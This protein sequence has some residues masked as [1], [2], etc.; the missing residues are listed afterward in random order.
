M[1]TIAVDAMGGD[2]CPKAEVSGAILAIKSYDVR[3]ILVGREDVGARRAGTARRLGSVPHSSSITRVSRSRWRTAPRKLSARRRTPPFASPPGWFAK[4][5]PMV[6]FRPATPAP[7]WRPPK[8]CREWCPVSIGPRWRPSFPSLKGT[9]VVVVDVGANVD[10]EPKM[11]AQFAVMGD[12]Y[13][14]SHLQA[15]Q[16]RESACSRSAKKSTKATSSRKSATPLLKAIPSLN[17]IGNVEGRDLYTGHA[18][19]IVCDGFIGNVALKVSEGIVDVIKQMLKESLQATVTPADRLPAV[20]I[21]VH[22]IQEACRL[23]RIRRRA[24]AR[25]EGRLHHL[26]RTIECQRDQERDPGGGRIRGRPCQSEDRRRSEPPLGGSGHTR[27]RYETAPGSG[28]VHSGTAQC[29]KPESCPVDVST[30]S[31]V[32]HGDVSQSHGKW[33]RA[34]TSTR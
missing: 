21:G 23:L 18:D 11:L 17:F 27:S 34:G 19:V 4:A 1:L 26:P 33:S 8:W 22:R 5:S 31:Q 28:V 16:S 3:V 7:S 9:P 32:R 13:S 15:P 24:A 14:R 30:T 10:C 20:A 25:S 29:A 6:S 12:I 2:H